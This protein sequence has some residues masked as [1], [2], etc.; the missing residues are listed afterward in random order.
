MADLAVTEQERKIICLVVRFLGSRRTS[1]ST[2]VIA[3]S[4][5]ALA[6]GRP[7][8][9]PDSRI[10][11]SIVEEDHCIRSRTAL[12]VMKTRTISIDECFTCGRGIHSLRRCKSVA[13]G[14]LWISR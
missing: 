9:I 11:N 2:T 4:V 7:D 13:N 8:V 6:K 14:I 12:L 5:K 1:V 3:H 10:H